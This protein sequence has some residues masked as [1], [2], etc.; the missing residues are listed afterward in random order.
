MV[1][2]S[3]FDFTTGDDHETVFEDDQGD[4]LTC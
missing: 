1:S 3:I 4:Y 2:D